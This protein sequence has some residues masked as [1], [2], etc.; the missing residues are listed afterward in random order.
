MSWGDPIM[1]SMLISYMGFM[2]FHYPI[3]YPV[4]AFIG[5]W[6]IMYITLNY[7]KETDIIM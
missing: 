1:F 4:Q 6:I 3:H 7:K 5:I 2:V